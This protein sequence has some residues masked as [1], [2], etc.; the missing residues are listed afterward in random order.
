MNNA[1][2]ILW[3]VMGVAAGTL[4]PLQNTVN[5]RLAKALRS[6]MLATGVS[7]AVGT[8][9]LGFVLLALRRHLPWGEAFAQQPAWIWLGGLFGVS[10]FTVNIILMQHFGA[11]ITV[12]FAICGQVI[13]GLAIDIFGI[14]DVTRQEPSFGRFAGTALV[15]AGAILVNMTTRL[16]TDAPADADDTARPG[17]TQRILLPVAGVLGGCL[18]AAQTTVNGRLGAVLGSPT[19]ASLASFS[20]G[21]SCIAL[22][23]FVTIRSHMHI[24]AAAATLPWWAWAGGGVLGALYVLVNAVDAPLLG[25]SLTVSVVLFGQIA[26]GLVIDHFGLLGLA[27]RPVTTQ[28]LAGAALVLIGIVLTRF[29]L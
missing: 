7:F 3:M 17:M 13:G 26:G 25:T 9:F 20:V 16:H 28:R 2:T 22:F 11:S 8:L 23:I 24:P 1:L 5:T 18:S 15:V 29:V 21:V 10:F 19:A 14:F 12:V 4:L 27:R 6:I